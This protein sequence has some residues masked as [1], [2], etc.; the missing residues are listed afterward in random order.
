MEKKI[1]DGLWT[2]GPAF[3]ISWL[4]C[5]RVTANRKSQLSPVA[6]GDGTE[7]H[8]KDRTSVVGR[9]TRGCSVTVVVLQ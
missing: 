5:A 1:A 9:D 3:G 4:K 7:R 6:G 2:I 8:L